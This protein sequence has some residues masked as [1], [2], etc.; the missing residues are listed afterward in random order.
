VKIIGHSLFCTCFYAHG[1]V[2][3]AVPGRVSHLGLFST[4]LT[5]MV[6]RPSRGQRHASDAGVGAESP[7]AVTLSLAHRAPLSL[8]WHSRQRQAGDATPL[9]EDV[10]IRYAGRARARRIGASSL[11]RAWPFTSAA[12]RVV[13]H[14]PKPHASAEA[15]PQPL[16]VMARAVIQGAVVHVVHAARGLRATARY[17]PEE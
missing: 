11:P 10:L 3:Q 17:R 12:Q 13:L 2:L 8:S 4:G 9:W 15:P 16:C 7:Q 14:R 5:I 1:K 6:N